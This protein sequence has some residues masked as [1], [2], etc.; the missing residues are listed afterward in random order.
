MKN[1][2]LVRQKKIMQTKACCIAAA[3]N[4]VYENPAVQAGQNFKKA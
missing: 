1:F 4:F 2:W 3:E